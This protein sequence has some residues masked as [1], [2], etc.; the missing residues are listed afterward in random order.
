MPTLVAPTADLHT[1]WLAMRDE[2]G[3]GV[4]QD[5]SGLRPGDEVDSPAGFAAWVA[6]LR[7]LGDESVPPPEG[8]VHA[9][10]WWIAGDDG[11]LLGAISL[12]YSLNDFLLDAGGHIGYGVRPSARGRGVA[13]W[14]LGAVLAAARG[15]GLGRVLV[16]CDETNPA[17]ARVIERHGGVLEDVRDTVLGRTRRYWI[18]L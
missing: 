4:H 17:S 2:W 5:G 3:R 10:F 1:A 7:R 6:K 11:A 13:T 18:T 9:A 15:R 12:R 16:T 8:W 14:A